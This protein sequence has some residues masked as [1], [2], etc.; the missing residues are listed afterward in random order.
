MVASRDLMWTWAMAAAS[1]GRAGRTS[2]VSP[3]SP[4]PSVFWVCVT[5]AP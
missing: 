4:V 3:D 2:A 5:G 1:A